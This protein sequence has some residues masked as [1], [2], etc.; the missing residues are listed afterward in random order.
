LI[1]LC[2]YTND[3]SFLQNVKFAQH[4]RNNL[5]GTANAILATF[6]HNSGIAGGLFLHGIGGI[7]LQDVPAIE[8]AKALLPAEDQFPV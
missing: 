6:C 2:P 7:D 4:F 3:I 1:L 8:I 5:N